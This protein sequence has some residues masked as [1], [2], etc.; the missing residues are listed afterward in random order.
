MSIPPSSSHDLM[1]S[2]C[3]RPDVRFESQGQDEK[4]ILVLRA[5]PFTQI[6]WVF[7]TLALLILFGVLNFFYPFFLTGME[8]VFANMF[9]LAVIFSYVFFN[10]SSWF[11]NVGVITN[12]RVV[13]IDFQNLLYKEVTEA[14]LKKIEDI[15]SK[16][17]G[18][19][20]S[21][22]NYGNLFVQTA[23]TEVNI[24]FLN[25]TRPADVV[26]II[27]DLTETI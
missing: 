22:F 26:R 24:E 10:F 25:I 6:H 12:E 3:L 13:D 27:Q 4:V 23:G 20:E 14:Q 18:F 1:H 15:T 11:F 17:G 9:F 5:H 7:N 16:S 19:F 8:A 2:F 21:F